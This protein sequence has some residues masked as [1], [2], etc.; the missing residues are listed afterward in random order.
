MAKM[1]MVRT[2]PITPLI[3]TVSIQNCPNSADKLLTPELFSAT[4]AV[5]IICS[6]MYFFPVRLSEG[7]RRRDH[8]R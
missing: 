8:D 5:P 7:S 1:K 4:L 2:V 6:V 3:G